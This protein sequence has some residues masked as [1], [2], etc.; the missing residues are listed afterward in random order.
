V[1]FLP[2]S[3]FFTASRV[4]DTVTESRLVCAKRDRVNRV[5]Q[6]RIS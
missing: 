2:L 5:V 4:A 6:V 1:M 3:Y